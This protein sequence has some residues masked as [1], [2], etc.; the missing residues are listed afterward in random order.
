MVIF[1]KLITPWVFK[2]LAAL[3]NIS[4]DTDLALRSFGFNFGSG[5]RQM[6]SSIVLVEGVAVA[7]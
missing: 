1:L 5:S 3:L 2:S 4:N 7:T 6:G